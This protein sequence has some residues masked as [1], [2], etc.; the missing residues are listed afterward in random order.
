MGIRQD[1]DY[2]IT[3]HAAWKA[4]FRNF[5]SGRGAMDIATVGSV[6]ACK[7]GDWLNNEA[8]HMLSSEDHAEACR[9]HARFHDVAGE[10]VRNIKAKQFAAARA[11][12]EPAAAFD[13]A[14]QELATFLR[15]MP[16]RPRNRSGTDN[17]PAPEGDSPA[18]AA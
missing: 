5:L 10:I 11:S 13:Q 1:I 2:A 6:H 8:R 14:S 7:L 18:E 4:Q 16:L 15:K 9:L 3:S 17:A 12:L